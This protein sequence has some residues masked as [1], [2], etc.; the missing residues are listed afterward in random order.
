MQSLIDPGK[1]VNMLGFK[2]DQ[3]P[4]NSQI[5]NELLI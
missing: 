5:S 4:P 2:F 3:V 1:K